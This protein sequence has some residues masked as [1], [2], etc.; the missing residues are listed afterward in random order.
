MS[1]IC[2][3]TY[4]EFGLIVMALGVG[5]GWVGSEWLVTLA[6]ALSLSF[7]L[8]APFYRR[9]ERFYDPISGRL[10]QFETAG[11]HPDDLPVRRNGE[12]IAIFGMGR[13]GLAAYHALEHRFPGQV[14][15]FDRDPTAIEAH[16][17]AERNVFLAD[18]T[19]SDFWERVRPRDDIDLVVLAMPKHSANVHAIET[20]K[21]HKFAGVVAVTGKYDDEIRELRGL[22]VDTAYNIYAQAG[23]GFATHVFN[24]FNQQYPDLVSSWGAAE[25]ERR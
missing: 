17:S 12:R 18:A 22:G 7:L 16:Q 19:D 11:R 5:Q 25:E 8:V 15:G 24:V 4:S 6:I 1:G 21:R 23:S 2:L 9:A 14:I 3:S 10:H 20:L 13:V